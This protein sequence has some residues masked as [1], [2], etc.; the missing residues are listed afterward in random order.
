MAVGGAVTAQATPDT[1]YWTRAADTR[2][3][4]YRFVY[5]Q[6]PQ[7]IPSAYDPVAEAEEI[8]RQRQ[9]TLP[10]TN[11]QAPSLWQRVRKI[12]IDTGLSPKLRAL[13]ALGLSATAFDVGW[14]IGSGLNAKFLR[15]GLPDPPAPKGGPSAGFLF[16]VTGGTYP[17]LNSSPL[18]EDGWILQYGY[19]GQQWQSV[20]LTYG[21]SDPCAY[22]T[23]PPVGFRVLAGT[24]Y[25]WCVWTPPVESY[26]LAEDELPAVGGIEAYTSQGYSVAT[27][28]PTAPSRSTVESTIDSRVSDPDND[29]I[30]QWFNYQVGSPGESDPAG[31]G[32]DNPDIPWRD[33]GLLPHFTKHGH[34]FSPAYTDPWEYWRDAVEI[35]SDP[36]DDCIR[37]RDG[38]EIY[39]DDGKQAIVIVKD[40]EIETYFPPDEGFEYFEF[41]CNDTG[42]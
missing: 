26:W 33:G 27:A 41:Q 1:E 14:K 32:A 6:S 19:A 10:P 29:E 39:W 17:N 15:V 11:P 25:G 2:D 23:G 5:G 21:W 42:A 9:A 7:A 13:G 4:V 38:A 28:A 8:L 30:K 34:K 31:I 40:G 3:T 35:I 24:G 37:P 18:P 16:F 22:L 36:D 12:T 20:N